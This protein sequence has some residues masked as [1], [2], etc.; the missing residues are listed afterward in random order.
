MRLALPVLLAALSA[1]NGSGENGSSSITFR[2]EDAPA[3]GR[4]DADNANLRGLFFGELEVVFYDHRPGEALQANTDFGNSSTNWSFMSPLLS[5]HTAARDNLIESSGNL[6]LSAL[7]DG[8]VLGDPDAAFIDD[9]GYFD[10]DIFEI[11]AYRTG[12]LYDTAGANDV[13]D[14]GFWGWATLTS[15]ENGNPIEPLHKYPQYDAVPVLETFP[16]F[17]GFEDGYPQDMN[18]LFTSDQLLPDRRLVQLDQAQDPSSGRYTGVR[19]DSRD[20]PVDND[21]LTATEEAL[22]LSLANEGTGRRFYDN[23]LIVPF[24]GPIRVVYDETA[25]GYLAAPAAP[26]EY[27][28]ENIEISVGMSL[29]NALDEARTSLTAAHQPHIATMEVL[30]AVDGQTYTFTLD[31]VAWSHTVDLST[32]GATP[33]QAANSIAQALYLDLFNEG[34]NLSAAGAVLTLQTMGDGY[35]THGQFELTSTD[36]AL[37]IT[38]VQQGGSRVVFAGDAAGIPFGLAYAVSEHTL[39]CVVATPYDLSTGAG[40]GGMCP[41]VGFGTRSADC[42]TC[43]SGTARTP[44]AGTAQF[45]CQ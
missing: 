3:A 5:G 12:I 36:T 22:I 2:I 19:F 8:Y 39:E 37:A 14:Y 40:T 38:E 32:S 35:L 15:D 4:R 41:P 34:F 9:V 13:A 11:N 44:V 16:F 23:L 18:I 17:P 29:V 7:A 25:P 30:S 26:S 33:E 31:G 43:P 42:C 20:N 27:R 1:C 45:T 6:D 24:P 21:P 10:I 28:A